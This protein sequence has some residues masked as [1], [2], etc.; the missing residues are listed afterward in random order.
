[1]AR[2]C[3]VDEEYADD[4]PAM[5]AAAVA[6]C[7][8]DP[9]LA[10]TT[11]ARLHDLWLPDLPHDIHLATATPQRPGSGMSRSR[12]PE[13]RAHRFQLRPQDRVHVHGLPVTSLARTWCD[14]ARILKLPDLVAAGDSALRAGASESELDDMVRALRG[15]RGVRRARTALPL[16]DRRS[17]S[18]PESHM[19]V[20]VSGLGLARFDVNSAVSRI[21]GGWLAEPDLSNVDAKIALEYQGE[22]HAK[23]RR[24]RRDLT[25]FADLRREGWLVLPYGPAEVFQRPWE[26]RAEVLEALRDRA[27]RLLSSHRPSGQIRPRMG[28]RT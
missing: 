28:A 24:M 17:R 22:D 15:S 6:S 12:R 14:L 4:L 13:F 9:T 21:D 11:A 25:R 7:G 20:A 27:P 8:A 19:R 5:C 10:V 2:D 18:R 1:M 16:L 23:V 26:I 3:Y